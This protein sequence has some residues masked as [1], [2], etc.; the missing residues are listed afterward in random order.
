MVVDGA[1]RCARARV[2]LTLCT[3][4]HDTRARR[5]STPTYFMKFHAQRRHGKFH[6]EFHEILVWANSDSVCV[7]IVT[8]RER[9]A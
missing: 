1:Y 6:D 8:H 4:S 5:L 7:S 3:R 9:D 2:V